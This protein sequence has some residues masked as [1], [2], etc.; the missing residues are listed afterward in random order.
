NSLATPAGGGDPDIKIST[1]PL[2]PGGVLCSPV[3]NW[4]CD[5]M[6]DA[7]NITVTGNDRGGNAAGNAHYGIYF[8]AFPDGSTDNIQVDTVSH[9]FAVGGDPDVAYDKRVTLNG[10]GTPITAISD[11]SAVQVP[12]ASDGPH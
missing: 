1:R 7:Q 10:G 6:R 12:S 4:K 3:G 2:F 11:P 8:D 5:A 9:N